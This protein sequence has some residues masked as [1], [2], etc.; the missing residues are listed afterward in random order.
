[1]KKLKKNFK[2]KVKVINLKKNIRIYEI[3]KIINNDL[4]YFYIENFVKIE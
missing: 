2:F 4:Y 3:L 1:M